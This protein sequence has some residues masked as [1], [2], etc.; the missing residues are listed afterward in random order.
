LVDWLQEIG[1]H[2]D[3]QP[4]S[5]IASIISVSLHADDFFGTSPPIGQ[6][7][8]LHRGVEWNLRS[9]LGRYGNGRVARL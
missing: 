3:P 6:G 9:S 1:S 2:L 8:P 5:R 4:V 7:R